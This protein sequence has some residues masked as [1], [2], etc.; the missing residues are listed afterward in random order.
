LAANVGML[1]IYDDDTPVK[2]KDG[3]TGPRTQIK[4][5]LSVGITYKIS[6]R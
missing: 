2:D 6:N 1:M 3:N 4:E 5:I